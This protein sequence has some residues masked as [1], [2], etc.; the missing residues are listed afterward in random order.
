MF[1]KL[2]YLDNAAAT[3]MDER[4]LEAMTP[5]F[6]DIFAVATSQFGY[7]A[8]IEAKEALAS[9]RAI[10]AGALGAEPEEFVF[11]SGSTESSNAALKARKRASTSLPRA[12]RTLQFCTAP[13]TWKNRAFRSHTW[14]WTNWGA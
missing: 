3:R 2:V 7:S 14:T 4:V 1:G 6:L 13:V 11:T 12:L 5:Y 8:G 9:S 10:I